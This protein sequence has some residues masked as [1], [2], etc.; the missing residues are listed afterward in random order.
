MMSRGTPYTADAQQHYVRICATSS[1][2]EDGF[3]KLTHGRS[4]SSML[5]FLI[6]CYP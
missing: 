4:T 3:R 2:L 6:V 5:I 1:T